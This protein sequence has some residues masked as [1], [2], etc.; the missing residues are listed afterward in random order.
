MASKYRNLFTFLPAYS[1]LNSNINHNLLRLCSICL[2]LFSQIKP[3]Y[4]LS[5]KYDDRA[6]TIVRSIDEY[7][8]Q[9]Y[10]FTCFYRHRYHQSFDNQQDS[11]NCKSLLILHSC[12]NY[13]SDVLRICY[14]SIL[15]RTKVYLENDTP[16][17]CF[18]SSVYKNFHA[19]HLRSTA[20]SRTFPKCPIV[21]LFLLVVIKIRACCW[22]YV[23]VNVK[24]CAIALLKISGE[25][26]IEKNVIFLWWQTAFVK[27]VCAWRISRVERCLSTVRESRQATSRKL[28][29]NVFRACSSSFIRWSSYNNNARG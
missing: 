1:I 14:Q 15:H 22:H 23:S 7:L 17:H 12:L 13:D 11:D 2:M 26:C 8:C 20:S 25:Q 5:S 16:K 4:S 19:Q 6:V 10:V 18:T 28:I 29:A 24:A 21:V 3:S 9:N 27:E